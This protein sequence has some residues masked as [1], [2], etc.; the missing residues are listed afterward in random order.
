MTTDY[1]YVHSCLEISIYMSVVEDSINVC[2][3]FMIFYHTQHFLFYD[4][5]QLIFIGRDASTSI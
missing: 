2:S 4:G 3:F 1:M 5:G